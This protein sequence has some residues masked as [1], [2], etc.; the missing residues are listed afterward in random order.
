MNHEQNDARIV[1]MRG[2]KQFVWYLLI[3]FEGENYVRK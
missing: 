2:M 1:E 3:Q